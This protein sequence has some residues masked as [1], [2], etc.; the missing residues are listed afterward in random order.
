MISDLFTMIGVVPTDQ[1]YC[2]DT[3]YAFTSNSALKSD[4]IYANIINRAKNTYSN[5][6]MSSIEKYILKESEDELK[7][8][9]NFRR[10]YPSPYCMKYKNYFEVERPF[11]FVLWNNELSKSKI[12]STNTNSI[13]N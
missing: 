13:T 8:S 1:R 3:S 2:V 7:R 10:L 6:E 11:N 9:R 4:K 5:Q 12:A